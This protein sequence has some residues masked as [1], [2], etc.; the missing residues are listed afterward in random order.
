MGHLIV[1]D[2]PRTRSW[3]KVV[4]LLTG[5]RGVGSPLQVDDLARLTATAAKRR[6]KQLQGDPSLTYCFWLLT[7]LASA[8]RGDQFTADLRQLGIEI[9]PD[10]TAL[11]LI[12]RVTDRTR[13]ELNRFPESGPFGEMASLALRHALS[14]TVG[15]EGRSL[16]GSSVEDLER[17][18]RKHS[19]VAQFGELSERFF[20]DF[21][22]RTLRYYVDRAVPA[23]VGS[24][25][26][27]SLVEASDVTQAL[28][29]HTRETARIVEQF[30]GEWF[31]KHHFEQA[32]VIGRDDAE[33]FVAYALGKLRSEFARE[34]E[35]PA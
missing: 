35:P 11:Q 28:T 25:G 3:L 24:D 26:L 8:S 16:L 32:G 29:L 30:A 14:E 5:G 4:D 19:T 31:S 20:G 1:G 9:R 27:P 12:A 23:A 7:R 6:L 13:V 33:R 22:A 34:Q 18:F 10:D 2:L 21:M 17:A 15:L